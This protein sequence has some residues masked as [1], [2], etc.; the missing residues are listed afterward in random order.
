[1][2]FGSV[3]RLPVGLLVRSTVATRGF[4][5]SVLRLSTAAGF[6]SSVGVVLQ[7]PRKAQQAPA[8]VAIRMARIS[9][10]LSLFAEGS[11]GRL[12]HIARGHREP[13]LHT[14]IRGYRRQHA[15]SS[16]DGSQKYHAPV[17]REA[18]GFVTVAVG[19][20]LDLLVA[21]VE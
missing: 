11:P 14:S 20:D 19:E 6:C 16:Y 12:P 21:E 13:L 5:A 18:R 1:M 9:C 15:A 7:A 8:R 2:L 3:S 4:C 17:R 10:L